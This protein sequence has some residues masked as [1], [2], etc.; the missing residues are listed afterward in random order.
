MFTLF[1]AG[2]VQYTLSCFQA[3]VEDKALVNC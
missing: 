1:A 2:H 3:S